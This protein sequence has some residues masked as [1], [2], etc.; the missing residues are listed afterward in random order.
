MESGKENII[1]ISG[2]KG[3]NIPM[4]N[5]TEHPIPLKHGHT[6]YSFKSIKILGSGA[7]I[8]G[9]CVLKDVVIFTKRLSAFLQ[10]SQIICFSDGTS[11]VIQSPSHVNKDHRHNRILTQR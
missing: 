4:E 5:A 6:I 3:V 1:F 10:L 7:R 8:A 2:L 9:S 11:V